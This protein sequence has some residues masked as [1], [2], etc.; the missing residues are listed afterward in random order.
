[1]K[2]QR[3]LAPVLL[4]R[5]EHGEWDASHIA[6]DASPSWQ[7]FRTAFRFFDIHK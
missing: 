1:M 5:R 7:A 3:L 4:N 6:R 2:N